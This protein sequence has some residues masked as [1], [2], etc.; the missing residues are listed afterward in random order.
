M[1]TSFT[2]QMTLWNV[3]DDGKNSINFAAETAGR[4]RG[5]VKGG[6]VHGVLYK[7][8]CLLLNLLLYTQITA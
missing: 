1:M 5:K 3:R 8:V 4:R 6:R 2:V 7:R